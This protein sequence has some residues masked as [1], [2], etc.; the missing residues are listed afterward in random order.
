MKWNALLPH[1]HPLEW[2]AALALAGWTIYKKEL[3]DWFRACSKRLYARLFP[4]DTAR[5]ITDAELKQIL[6]G[7]VT[8]LQTL[9]LVLAKEY[10]TDRVSLV[11]FSKA[12]DGSRLSTCLVEVREWE[13]QSVDDLD[14]TPVPAAL[15]TES[16]RINR[17]PARCD[18]VPDA[19]LHDIAPV[20]AALL[21]LGVR[22][23]YYQMMPTLDGEEPMAALSFSWR[24][25]KPLGPD[26]LTH[27]HSSGIACAGVLLLMDAWR[28]PAPTA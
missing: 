13:M 24:R 18:Y 7:G 8:R 23:A 14:A 2:A 21:R 6:K 26:M 28:P 9:L 16:C 20:R 17:L 12:A 4:S 27:L 22:S 1:L 11:Q 3:Q 25:D 15:W 5:R 19:R 10:E